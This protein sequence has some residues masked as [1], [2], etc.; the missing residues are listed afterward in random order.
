MVISNEP[1]C[2]KVGKFG[3]RIENL[4]WVKKKK[5]GYVFDDLTMAPIDKTLIKKEILKPEEINWLNNYHKKVFNNLKRF[6]NKTELYEFKTCM[7]QYLKSYT[8]PFRLRFEHLVDELFQLFFKF[9]I[10]I[11]KKLSFFEIEP[12]TFPPVF[13]N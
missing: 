3:I 4:I 5:K 6:M 9:R 10:S 8:T 1:G 2:Y 13:F 7:F 12:K 11:T